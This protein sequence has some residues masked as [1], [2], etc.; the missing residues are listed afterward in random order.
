MMLAAHKHTER[1]APMPR[2]PEIELA[3]DSQRGL[4]INTTICC[5]EDA[6]ALASLVKRL[7]QSLP[8]A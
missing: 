6:D 5:N 4:Q 7:E 3:Y 1:T 2:F 8:S